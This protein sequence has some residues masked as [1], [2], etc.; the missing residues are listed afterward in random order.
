MSD[1]NQIISLKSRR[2]YRLEQIEEQEHAKAQQEALDEATQRQRDYVIE[3][4]EMLLQRAREGKLDGFIFAGRNPETDLF[5]TEVA[6]SY[7]IVPQDKLL[8]YLG[9]TEALKL[10]VADWAAM[11]RA[12]T[13][14]GEIVDPFENP[15]VVNALDEE[16]FDE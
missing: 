9:V 13:V 3:R 6:I 11:S 5:V 15:E 16:D 14:E 7:P 8:G 2:P 12:E 1:E 10:E 4:L